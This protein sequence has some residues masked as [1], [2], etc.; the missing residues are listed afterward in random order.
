V[1]P[2]F[3]LAFVRVLCVLAG[4]S[5]VGS[6]PRDRGGDCICICMTVCSGSAWCVRCFFVLCTI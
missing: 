1:A 3:D 6:P 2:R 5:S 4:L